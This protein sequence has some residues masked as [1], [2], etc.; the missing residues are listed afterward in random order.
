MRIFTWSVETIA[1]LSDGTSEVFTFQIETMEKSYQ[2]AMDIAFVKTEKIL[3]RQKKDFLRIIVS[4]V[5]IVEVYTR[6]KYSQ[7]KQLA[8]LKKSRKT[9]QRLLSIDFSQLSEFEKRFAREK[10]VRASKRAI[11]KKGLYKKQKQV[12]EKIAIDYETKRK[13]EK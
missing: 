1:T 8:Q 13:S 12:S 5:E 10:R 7:Y 9:I 3:E 6:S 11:K 4:W 2:A